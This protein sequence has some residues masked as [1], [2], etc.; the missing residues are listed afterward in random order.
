M[1][2]A[3]RM[4]SLVMLGLVCSQTAWG[5]PADA[6]QVV[7]SQDNWDFGAVWH[8]EAPTLTLT[9]RNAGAAELKI[10]NV[11]PTC[12]CT[13]VEPGRRDVPPGETTEL[14][15]R[16][17][18]KGKQD[19]VSSSVI[20]ESNDPAR[21]K[22]EFPIAGFVKRAVRRIPLAG[23]S[24]RTLDPH[25]GQTVTVRLENT[26]D[27]PMQPKL[28][29]CSVAGLDVELKEVTA[30][31]VYDVVGRITQSLRHGVTRGE[32]NFSTGLEHEPQLA[33][34]A[35][36]QLMTLVDP[37]PALV[38]LDPRA[39]TQPGQRAINLNYYGTL[40]EFQV[41][42]T[43]CKGAANVTV[44]VGERKTPPAGMEKLTPRMKWIVPTTVSLPSAQALPP[45]GLT[46]EYTTNDPACP[47]VEVR[48]TSNRQEW[49]EF[50]NGPSGDEGH[51]AR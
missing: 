1:R 15:I 5:E 47:T 38:Y 3:F 23:F 12:G 19:R 10:T 16:Y 21:P 43:K 9:I 20:I 26:T 30:G 4:F 42:R 51:P 22:L 29:S 6:P 39:T 31:Q 37:V 46:I 14:K 8:P 48:I 49:Q 13:S 35:V 24:L 41:T 36:I 27:R 32:L 18:T 45:G 11:K 25:P 33:V 7:L 44:A 34:P 17:D 50:V 28:L 40:D 2:R